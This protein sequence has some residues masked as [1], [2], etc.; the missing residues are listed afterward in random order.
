MKKVLLFDLDNTLLDFNAAEKVALSQV[1]HD[2]DVAE[3]PENIATYKT[4]NRDLWQR[5]ESGE[6]PRETITSE[7][8]PRLF[9]AINNPRDGLSAEK[10]YRYNLGL[11][12]V[13][14]PGAHNVLAQ[15]QKDYMLCLVTNGVADT[16]KM[17]LKNTG[18]GQFFTHVFISDE[19]GVAKPEPA[20]FD[21]V[22]QALPTFSKSEMLVVGDS[23]ASDIKGGNDSH[24]ETAWLN[25]THLPATIQPT[26]EIAALSELPRL[27]KKIS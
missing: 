15:L 21:Y 23:L 27:L 25:P 3:T 22:T 24:I 6:I 11:S 9:A 14:V 12:K 5:Y 4:I 10:E 20:F 7:R 13:E 8:F 26:Y 1:F 16:Q 17:R 19:L 18:F 2:Y